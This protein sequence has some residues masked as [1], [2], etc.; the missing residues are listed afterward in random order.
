MVVTRLWLDQILSPLWR[1]ARRSKRRDPSREG[2][3]EAVQFESLEV[4]G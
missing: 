4:N 2:V 1:T 3:D